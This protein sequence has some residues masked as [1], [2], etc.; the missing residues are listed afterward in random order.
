VIFSL[1]QSRS[2]ENSRWLLQQAKDRRLDGELRK[3]ALFWAGQSGAAVSDLAE[4]YDSAENDRELRNQVIF[5]LSQRRRDAA[6]MD[7][8][9]EIAQRDS[10]PELRKQAIFWLGQSGDAR[11]AKLIED[12]INKPTGAGR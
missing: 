9:F 10:D 5:V 6:A 8:L 3:S 4:I 12:I 11:A 1:S 7:K 2:A